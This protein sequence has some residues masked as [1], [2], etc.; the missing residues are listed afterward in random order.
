MAISVILKI[1]RLRLIIGMTD[2]SEQ[3]EE[4]CKKCC[5]LIFQYN[6]IPKCACW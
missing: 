2:L 3:T 6:I 5:F 1:C 4:D